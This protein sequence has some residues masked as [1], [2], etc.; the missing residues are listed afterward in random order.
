MMHFLSGHINRTIH[1]IILLAFIPCLFTVLRF[2]FERNAADKLAMGNRIQEVVHGISAQQTE[3][4][5]NVRSTLATLALMD[6]IRKG[7]YESSLSL[8][9][10]LLSENP[11]MVNV[12]LADAQG[13][14]IASGRG[15]SE[16]RD[17][18]SLPYVREAMT[19][20]KFV[21]SRYIRDIATGAATI[22]CIYPITDYTGLRGILIGAVNIETTAQDLNSLA[23]LPK[24]S[25][26][27]ADDLGKIVS[28]MPKDGAYAGAVA[29]PD[30]ESEIVRAAKA[31]QGVVRLNEG[32]GDER[33][34]AFTKLRTRDSKQWFLTYIV[35][36]DAAAADAEADS[37]L[38]RSMRD[39]AIA[40]V[41]GFLVA[42][43][44]SFFALRRPLNKLLMAV[45][46]LGEGRLDAR[47][48]L[49]ALSGEVGKLAAGFDSMAQAIESTH[50]ELVD[51]KQ[52]A[53]AASQAKSEFLANMSHEIRTPMNAIIGMAY[54][55]LKTDLTPRQEAYINKIYLAANTLLGI[56]NDILDFS[57]IEAGKLD[58]ENAPFLLEE[59]FSTVTTLVAQKAEEKDLELLFS[60]SPDVPQS[61]TGDPLRLGQVLTNIISNAIKFTTHGEIMVSCGLEQG[62]NDQE[63]GL[64]EFHGKS[65]RLLFTVRDTGIGMTEEQKSKLF[66]P[67]T[68]ADNSTT[69]LYGGTGLGLTITKRLIEMMDGTVTIESEVEKGTTV[70]FSAS[71]QCSPYPE[72]PRYATSL[73][74][75]RVLVVDDN[76][77]ARTIFRDM[78]TG[79]TLVPTTVSSALEAYE[80]LLRADRAQQSYRLVLLDWR[81]PEI[82]GIEAAA[83]MQQM[84][85]HKHPSIILVTAFGRS[86]LQSEAESVG[87]R[88]VLYKPISPS[89]LFNTVL[90]AVQAEGRLPVRASSGASAKLPSQFSGLKVLIVEDNIVNQQV[91][92]EI[93]SQ[94]GVKVALANNG[95]EAVS[96]LAER[97]R[98]FHLVL[99][100]L[101]MPVMDGYAATRALRSNPVFSTLPIIAMTAHAMSGERE[102]CIAAGMNDHL[103]KPIEVEKLFQVLRRWAVVGG[104]RF[105][106]SPEAED[107]S[108]PSAE[109]VA[110]A[111]A[112]PA[113]SGSP[114]PEPALE[115]PSARSSGQPTAAASGGDKGQQIPLPQLPGIDSATA[116]ARLAGSS[117]LYVKTLCMFLK[118]I[119]YHEQELAAAFEQSDAQRLRR[120]AHT[121]KGL[122]ATVGATETAT[123]AEHMEMSLNSGD[124]LPEAAEVEALKNA[125]AALSGVIAASGLCNPD[126]TPA[127]PGNPVPSSD[128]PPAHE[129]TETLGEVL[130]ALT[131]LLESDDAKAPGYF[132]EHGRVFAVGLPDEVRASLEESLRK[133]DYDA[134]LRTIKKLPA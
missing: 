131:A 15:S 5:E 84:R 26:V 79:L 54:L 99:M 112:S 8:F 85:L 115:R 55:A 28:T 117:R 129:E 61:L 12:L 49:P 10:S 48:N 16:G 81:M 73:A 127:V 105:P 93:L 37:S 23:F 120:A 122:T 111:P 128:P 24:A 62:P 59:V 47:S 124:A 40:L 52:A 35:S 134:A 110:T 80:E 9:A 56:I 50:T 29:L 60:I 130:S 101:Q 34:L 71:F 30:V 64:A 70:S 133:F 7:H 77:M 53:D 31:D 119:P 44:V 4:V 97:P 98:D 46:L 88:Q 3:V 20:Q 6:D 17:L 32:R 18:S 132:A 114:A 75:L 91:A 43:L 94:E 95:Q 125:L 1:F 126:G 27:L 83:H 109:D 58:I 14:I 33:L 36:I 13:K 107:S 22:Y 63:C 11:T 103:A 41:A 108:R 123:L 78:L 86:E 21:V 76:E 69:R 45:R 106:S 72:Q 67:F 66:R 92:A 68:Q 82:S 121:L 57:K 87:I 38:H 100:D 113:I 116:V 25:L 2:G 74:G 89:Q 51:A 104:Y 96:M 19:S 65:V 39:L 118:S 90:E 102:A 42:T